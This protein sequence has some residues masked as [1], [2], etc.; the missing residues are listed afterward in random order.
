ML[1]AQI[2]QK[3]PLNFFIFP[4]EW[5]QKISSNRYTP[6][7]PTSEGGGRSGSGGRK[8][9][10]EAEEA[11]AAEMTKKMTNETTEEATE[12]TTYGLVNGC[13]IQVLKHPTQAATEVAQKTII[14]P[15]N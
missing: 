6:R 7:N 10:A 13:R 11:T 15:V 4:E 8:T 12:D 1:A 2:I 14:S 3:Q 9:A 5:T